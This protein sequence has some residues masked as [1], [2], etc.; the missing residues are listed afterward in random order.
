MSKAQQRKAEGLSLLHGVKK[1]AAP[2]RNLDAVE[3]FSAALMGWPTAP[4]LPW[5][6]A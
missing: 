6:T 2:E 3:N 4:R 1:S 5:T